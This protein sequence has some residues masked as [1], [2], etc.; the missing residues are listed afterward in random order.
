[1]T[2][3]RGAAPPVAHLARQKARQQHRDTLDQSLSLPLPH[4]TYI[5]LHNV[6]P[7]ARTIHHEAALAAA[8]DGAARQVV[9]R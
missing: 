9:F 3:S 8:V 1:M 7:F 5:P 2:D 4:H 6:G